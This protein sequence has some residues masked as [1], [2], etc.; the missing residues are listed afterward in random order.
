MNLKLKPGVKFS[1][2]GLPFTDPRTG[3][4]FDGY[5]DSI[6]G[7]VAKII[8]HRWRN[9][10]HYPQGEVGHFDPVLVRQEFYRQLYGSRPDLFMPLATPQIQEVEVAPNQCHAC[11][12]AD[13]EEELCKTCSGRRVIGRKCKTCGARQRR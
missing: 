2:S 5:Q 3:A 11:G 1:P 7:A 13:I 9:P 10:I 4:T 8:E 12:S 6:S